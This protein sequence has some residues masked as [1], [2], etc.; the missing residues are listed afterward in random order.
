M[1]ATA[2]LEVPI[3]EFQH[4]AREDTTL[5]VNGLGPQSGYSLSRNSPKGLFQGT[6]CGGWSTQRLSRLH[7]HHFWPGRMQ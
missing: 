7:L 6:L 3:R 2:R 5:A 1:K 4:T